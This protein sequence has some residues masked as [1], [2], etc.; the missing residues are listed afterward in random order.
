MSDGSPW[1]VEIAGR[2]EKELKRL[3]PKDQD[4]IRAAIDALAGGPEHGDIKKLQGPGNEWRLRVGD[5][6][7]RFRPDFKDRIIYILHVL[8]RGK[9]YRD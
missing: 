3:S 2:A 9:A 6:R 8:P 5:L 1:R 4:R 7:V